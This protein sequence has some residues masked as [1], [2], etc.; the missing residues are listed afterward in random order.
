MNEVD[1]PECGH[2]FDPAERR[3]HVCYNCLTVIPPGE[4]LNDHKPENC[5]KRLGGYHAFY[6]EGDA[7]GF[8]RERIETYRQ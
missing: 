8:Q 4:E 2:T 7:R 1:C 3:W 6:S 5:I